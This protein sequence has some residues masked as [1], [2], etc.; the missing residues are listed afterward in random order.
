MKGEDEAGTSRPAFQ[1]P[2]D[3][4]RGLERREARLRGLSPQSAQADFVSS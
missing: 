2:G 4:S 1:D 3:G